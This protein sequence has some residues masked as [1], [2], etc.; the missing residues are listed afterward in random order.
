MPLAWVFGASI[1]GS[2]VG[3]VGA[4]SAAD[5]QAAGQERAA[6][7][8]RDMFNQTTANEQP[9]MN[10]GYGASDTL[11]QLMGRT[12]TP[13]TNVGD[14]GLA[15]GYLTQQFNPTQAQM[16]AYPGYQFARDQGDQAVRNADTPNQGALS[17]A[18]LKDL[19][20]FNVGTANQFYGQYFNQFQQQQNN[21]FNRLSGIASLGQNAAAGV[22][23]NGAQLGTGIAQAQAGAAASQA[24]G[25]VGATNSISGGLNTGAGMMYLNANGNSGERGYGGSGSN[26]NPSSFYAQNGMDTG[27]GFNPALVGP[28]GKVGGAVYSGMK[29][30]DGTKMP[31]HLAD[32]GPVYSPFQD[33]GE[34]MGNI[35]GEG[36][37]STSPQPLNQVMTP[38]SGGM[39]GGMTG[40][41]F[42]GMTGGAFINAIP[43]SAPDRVVQASW[44]NGGQNGGQSYSAQP[45]SDPLSQ[46]MQPSQPAGQPTRVD[47]VPQGAA[48]GPQ[49]PP[50]AAPQ[51]LNNMMGQ[52]QQ[53]SPEPWMNDAGLEVGKGSKDGGPIYGPG[54]PRDDKVPAMLSNGEHVVDAASVN[55]MGGGNNAVGQ[56]RL[57]KLRE[58]LQKGAK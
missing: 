16:E 53:N 43:N 8:Q 37:V 40:G 22:G 15:Q 5:T 31:A 9:Y 3:A 27:G 51:Q 28:G 17:G 1:L 58:L 4:T 45:F 24:G 25:I 41:I 48:N 10:A 21:V 18:T 54:G 33:G 2:V 49:T 57:N 34:G 46:L 20:K 12:G 14:T 50:A 42:G 47:G 7:T 44:P 6:Q 11:S 23:N 29:K 52:G 35:L 36:S 55:A 26:T 56:K 30:F 38:Q 39:T 19:M 13:G 32:G